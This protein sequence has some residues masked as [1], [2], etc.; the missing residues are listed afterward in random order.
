MAFGLL[1]F[2]FAAWAFIL[3]AMIGAG[4]MG[5]LAGKALLDRI[6]QALFARLFK[7]TLT[8]LALRLLWFGVEAWI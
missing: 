6:P 7:L 5:T 3:A 4:F 2:E 1:G 8:A